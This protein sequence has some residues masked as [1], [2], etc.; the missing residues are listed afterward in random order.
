MSDE[1]FVAMRQDANI[2]VLTELIKKTDI[3]VQN[4]SGWTPLYYAI[5][6]CKEDIS[7][8]LIA[9]KADVNIQAKSKRTPLMLAVNKPNVCR[10]LV[11]NK[12]NLFVT[13]DGLNAYGLTAL[14]FA[15]GYGNQNNC[16][17]LLDCMLKPDNSLA[18]ILLGIKRYRRSPSFHMIGIDI[19]KALAKYTIVTA[20]RQVVADQ[21]KLIND[22]S[23]RKYLLNCLIE[24]L[25]PNI[26]IH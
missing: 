19:V 12:A 15:A 21:I 20:R 26:R 8:F 6:L 17:Y 1:L 10:A 4:E 18:V 3:N 14:V 24:N 13:Y 5:A 23:I 2:S 25:L 7:L 9:N 16:K 11:E 22:T